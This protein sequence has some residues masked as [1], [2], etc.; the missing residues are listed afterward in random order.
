MT[1]TEPTRP[2]TSPASGLDRLEAW[3]VTGSQDLYGE[4]VLQKVD[5]NSR[6]IARC[7]AEAGDIPVRVVAT[8]VVTP[9]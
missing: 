5:E 7:L 6:H 2:T 3:F 8:P 1:T 4:A 9:R